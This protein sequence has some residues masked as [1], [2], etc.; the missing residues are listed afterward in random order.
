MSEPRDEPFMRRALELAARGKTAPNPHVGA[1]VVAEGGAPIGEG[2]HERAGGP[3]AETVALAAAGART[4]GA[5]LYCTLE[6]CNHHGRTPP[7]TESIVRA[8][9]RRVVVGCRDPRRHLDTSGL[10]RLREAGIE[11]REGVLEDEA[12]EL[13]ADFA[14][15]ALLGRPLV[16]L[17][18]A[19]TLDGRIAT[20][21]GDSKWITGELARREAHRLRARAD[22]ILVGV[23]T[24][25]ADDPRLDARLAPGPE[26]AATPV[27]V[28]ADTALGT[29]LDAQIVRT[30]RSQATWIAHAPDADPARARALEAL[31]VNL[32]PTQRAPDGGLDLAALLA[33][34][35]RRDVLYLLVEGGGRIAGAL[36]DADLVDRAS[37][38]V[39]PIIVGDPQAPGLA[40]RRTPPRTLA[41]AVRLDRSV[42]T[43]LG[44]DMMI[45][46][47]IRTLAW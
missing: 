7:C 4:R 43:T 13:V 27:R 45:R 8:G 40:S 22:A 3:H 29:P 47:R 32:L 39:A 1:V 12:R 25:R 41:S 16:E 19:V 38:F 18:S 14:T 2:F 44:P 20:R 34:L 28:V 23:G 31:G 24:V 21:T 6:P 9:I 30:A 26:S 15:H 17:K 10:S 5:T 36:L 37:V 35:A 46:G 42:A 11:V 33:A